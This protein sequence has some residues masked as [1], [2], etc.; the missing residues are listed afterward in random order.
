MNISA[1]QA[2]WRAV[3]EIG[4]DAIQHF[5]SHLF[6]AH[7]EV[8]D[9][10]PVSMSTQRDRFFAALGHIVTNVESLGDDPSFV[11]HLGRDHRRFG[12]V[13]AHYPAAGA[14]LLAT[15]EH[16]HGDAWTPE[17]AADWGAAYEA[18]AGLMVAA[19]A[20]AEKDTPPWW[21]ADVVSV[22]RKGLDFVLVELQP[23]IPFRYR[24]GQSMAIEVPQRPR[25]WRY[26]SPAA[27]PRPDGVLELHIEVIP[28][29]Q[30]TGAIARDLVPGHSVKL[31]AP[32]GN[33]LTI[34]PD[35]CGDLLLIAGGSGLAPLRAVIQQLDQRWGTSGGAPNVLLF[36]GARNRANL[37]DHDYLTHMSSREWFTYVPVVSEDPTFAGHRG[38]VG[39]VAAEMYWWEGYTAL[40][41]G[42]PPMVEHTIGELTRVGLDPESISY[43]DF[44]PAAPSDS[45]RTAIP[46]GTTNSLEVHPWR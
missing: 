20:D 41:C 13:A 8:R 9:M 45:T 40:V 46:S 43:E 19:A 26:V 6:L 23:R 44:A 5:Y 25:Q 22:Q 2:S 42:S 28:G 10:F 27:A 38:L 18:V 15:L 14:S 4:D 37:Y 21:D 3:V 24:P 36:H 35:T 30:V 11:Q 16:F 7:P 39:T 34:D 1:L 33:R 17:L 31:G 32:I 29:G 12:V